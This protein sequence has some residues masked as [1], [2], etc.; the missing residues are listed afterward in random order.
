MLSSVLTMNNKYIK[1]AKISED[2]FRQLL[3]LFS[4]DL[5]AIQIS[6]IIGLSRNTVNRYLKAIY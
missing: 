5:D 1:N 2:K 4:V 3:K 6:E